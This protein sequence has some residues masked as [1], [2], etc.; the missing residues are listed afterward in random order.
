MGGQTALSPGLIATCPLRGGQ[1]QKPE[2]FSG[3]SPGAVLG[4]N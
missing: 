1:M 3:S 2:L 4:L